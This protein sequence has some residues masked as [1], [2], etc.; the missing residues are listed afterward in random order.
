[1]SMKTMKNLTV[2]TFILLICLILSIVFNAEANSG[3]FWQNPLPT[4]G[5]IHDV[6]VFDENHVYLAIQSGLM[7][8]T[9]DGGET[10][11]SYN[12]EIQGERIDS[13]WDLQFVDENTGF[14]V[15][16][17]EKL[18]VNMIFASHLFKTQDGGKNWELVKIPVDYFNA[19]VMADDS[20]GWLTQRPIVSES[21]IYKTT[22]CAETWDLQWSDNYWVD[23]IVAI[24]ALKVWGCSYY[25]S[26]DRDSKLIK[27][28]D[29]GE[30]W[31][32]GEITVDDISIERL[33][34]LFFINDSTGWVTVDTEGA[35]NAVWRTDD[36]G[37]TWMQQYDKG[38]YVDITDLY[39][40]NAD[41]GFIVTQDNTP[42]NYVVRTVDGGLT[43]E[44]IP[45]ET[46]LP[47]VKF[48][49]FADERYGWIAGDKG[50]IYSTSDFGVTWESKS[51]GIYMDIDDI[52]FADE[53]NG[54]VT[55]RGII[56]T[57]DGGNTWEHLDVPFLER[58][59]HYNIYFLNNNIGWASSNDSTILKT[60][61]GGDSWDSIEY[62]L[63][64]RVSDVY[65][66]DE[67]NGFACG[68][69]GT[70]G[71]TFDGGYN[72]ESIDLFINDYLASFSFLDD[73]TGWAYSSKRVTRTTDAGESWTVSDTIPSSD[74]S[75]IRDLYYF[76]ELNGLAIVGKPS[77]YS[78][79]EGNIWRT[80]DGG[81]TWELQDSSFNY[82]TCS[83]QFTD[84]MKGWI[85][86]YRGAS[87]GMGAM[88][89][90]G[91]VY[92]TNDGGYTWIEEKMPISSLQFNDVFFINDSTGWITTRKGSI[93]KTTT[94]GEN[95]PGD[96]SPNIPENYDLLDVYPN[97]FNSTARIKVN[98]PYDSQLKLSVCNILGQRVTSIMNE[99]FSM[100]QYDFSFNA[101]DQASGIYFV[102]ATI[103][104]VN[105][106][107][108]AT[109]I[110]KIVLI[111]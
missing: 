74:Y 12:L 72:W 83:L 48:I 109:Q 60:L 20:T 35:R 33:L 55:G 110:K 56:R 51:S 40:V 24:D 14:V 62:T 13:L 58:Y 54:W 77:P 76:D 2:S 75:S 64:S 34:D 80:F 70:I 26:N 25:A 91:I 89:P 57:K 16:N 105:G 78:D 36:S 68:S 43:W 79:I 88:A 101:T 93:L 63:G 18:G 10:W 15:C 67:M 41:T 82:F 8:Q 30:T 96:N 4:G 102:Q 37:E 29:G 53:M 19:F 42:G 99:F 44:E 3:W 98:L 21:K 108:R 17:I 7:M 28:S 73:S 100:G 39:F 94:A 97:P 92:K 59:N 81:Q 84:S 46:D 103:N 50:A 32:Y 22:D 87:G 86:G 61:D 11:E 106:A 1:M 9:F 111:K 45:L 65:F 52:Y 31:E 71:R 47:D 104:P 6:W 107:D 5:D 90:S 69:Q 85:V 27:S 23:K 49:H 66:F 38:P 95:P